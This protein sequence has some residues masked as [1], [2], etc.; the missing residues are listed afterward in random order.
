M[1]VLVNTYRNYNLFWTTKLLY[2]WKQ[3]VCH[4]H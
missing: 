1:R 3:Y 2:L 4:L